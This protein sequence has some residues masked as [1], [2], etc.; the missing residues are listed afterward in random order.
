MLSVITHPVYARLFSAQVIA[1]I[2]TGLMTVALGLLAYDL[3]GEAA[4][5]VLGTA[6]AIKMVAYVGLS[7]VAAAL[8][9][10]M[11]R[12]A[13]LVGADL[14]RAAVALALPFIDA[15]WQVYVLI[16]VLQA[17]SASFTPAFQAVIPDVLPE[18]GDYTRALSLSRLAYD[19]ESLLSP[20]L[21]GVLLLVMSYHGLFVGTVVGFLGSA[22][23]V[24]G[25]TLPPRTETQAQRP[26]SERLTRGARI[27][28]ATPRL[29][30]L[31]ALNLAAAA[32]GA[33]VIVNTVVIVQ[34]G[35]GA[36]EAAVATALAAFGGGSMLAALALP[37]LLDHAAD[38]GVMLAAA[39][40]L[41]GLTL[42][43]G[44]WVVAA[45][46]PGWGV[47]LAAWAVIGFAY[48]AVLTPAGRLL[49]RSSHSGDRPALFAAQFALSHAC[50]LVTYPV[51]G[52]A[53]NALGMGQALLIL[54]GIA[55]AGVALALRVWPAGDPEVV[56]HGH[57]DLPPDHPHLKEHGGAPH[58]HA[59]V[60][61]DEHQSWPTQG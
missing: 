47:L 9:E 15:V 8:A 29:R 16:F 39:A 32:A 58:R 55:V 61:D 40:G 51:A 11:P 30:G 59:F 43:L 17:A 37:A 35:Y 57:P 6:L 34:A 46:L 28:L 22:L 33:F 52:W 21:A 14:I 38:R 25:T 24:V 50:W 44:A 2:G 19:L 18:E 31:L 10:R 7:P 60:I 53:G 54:G 27:Y 49:R 23:L 12:K 36:G 3:A 45:G 56:A 20:A 42:A 4:G 1:L 48:A 5:A 41:T 13:V 26:F